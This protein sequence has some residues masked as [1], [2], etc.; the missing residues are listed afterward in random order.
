MKIT[1]SNDNTMSESIE[2]LSSVWGA[3]VIWFGG[4]W[5][6]VLFIHKVTKN[7]DDDL[8]PVKRKAL[9]D[10]LEDAIAENPGDWVSDFTNVFDR[11]F[12]KKHLRLRCFYRSALISIFCFII[13]SLNQ[14]MVFVMGV[15]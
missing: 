9:S 14:G 4:L 13:L 2:F 1:K 3:A 6:I 5:A 10:D 8:D 7:A 11:F 15:I 12:G